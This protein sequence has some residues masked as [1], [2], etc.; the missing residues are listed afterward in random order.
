M[1]ETVIEEDT[2][3]TEFL[4]TRQAAEMLGVPVARLSRAV[5]DGRVEEPARSPAGDFLWS[6]DDVEAASW[7]LRHC[8]VFDPITDLGASSAD[9]RR[10]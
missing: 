5:W 2:A 9:T 3:M 7:R 4:N 1:S 6:P 8:S 10:V